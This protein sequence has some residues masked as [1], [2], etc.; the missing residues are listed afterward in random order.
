MAPGKVF[1]RLQHGCL[2]RLPSVF[3]AKLPTTR[4]K[5]ASKAE[6]MP[7]R[8]SNK[9]ELVSAPFNLQQ[10]AEEGVQLL[11][12]GPRGGPIRGQSGGGAN[13]TGV[14]MSSWQPVST[15]R[16]RIFNRDTGGYHRSWG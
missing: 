13:R 4:C 1:L 5:A 9:T 10:R 12:S 8:W 2:A 6:I 11:P 16:P 3:S 7:S 14:G 15:A